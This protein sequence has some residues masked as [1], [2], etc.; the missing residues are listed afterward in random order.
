MEGY[1]EINQRE[2]DKWYMISL[3]CGITELIKMKTRSWS[4]GKWGEIGQM[5][6]ISSSKVSKFCGSNVL[7]SGYS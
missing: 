5:V 4:W 6:Q 2:K 3:I 7:Y 1:P